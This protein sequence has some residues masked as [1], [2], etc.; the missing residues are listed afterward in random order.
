MA[1]PSLSKN[2]GALENSALVEGLFTLHMYHLNG[3][4]ADDGNKVTPVVLRGV[5]EVS[6]DTPSF[7]TDEEYFH[8]GGGENPLRNRRG[9]SYSG[10][11]SVYA[12]RVPELVAAWKEQTW[13]LAE[14][15]A[16]MMEFQDYPLFTLESACR[17]KSN[18]TVMFSKIWQD[19]IIDPFQL[20]NPMDVQ[21][22]EIPFNSNY[23]SFI[24]YP[25]ARLVMDKFTGDN[26]QTEFTLSETPLK[27][28]T[29]SDQPTGSWD[30]EYAVYVKILESGDE[31]PTRQ[32]SGLTI[33]PEDPAVTFD[34][35]PAD[36]EEITVLYAYDAS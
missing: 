17:D 1:F 8:Q 25:Q 35:A 4:D 29:V 20:P 34:T 16:V 18:S 21:Y 13:S 9:Y 5:N 33:T 11:I 7:D 27:L 24:L 36:G 23:R 26:C 32:T 3:K 10:N 12:G 15:A 2:L 30:W 14:D 19:L 31:I 22:G 28:M 6:P